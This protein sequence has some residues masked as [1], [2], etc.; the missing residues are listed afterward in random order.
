MLGCASRFLDRASDGTGVR[1]K[2]GVEINGSSSIRERRQLT[3]HRVDKAGNLVPSPPLTPVDRPWILPYAP[4]QLPPK[5]ALNR[6]LEM[7]P[8]AR[9]SRSD[10][11]PHEESVGEHTLGAAAAAMA[12]L[13][14]PFAERQRSEDIEQMQ[15]RAARARRTA[16]QAAAIR[17]EHRMH[18]AQV[19]RRSAAARSAGAL[20]TLLEEVP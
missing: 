12:T 15:R 6:E 19:K 14:T 16:K 5:L 2:N 7:P 17:E 9:L 8:A 1:Q 13:H 11:E 4:A 10:T 20:P 18:I 3:I